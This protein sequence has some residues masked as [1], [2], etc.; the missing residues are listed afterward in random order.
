[1]VCGSADAL[2]AGCSDVTVANISATVLLAIWDNLLCVTRRPGYLILTGFETA[3]SRVI[4]ELVP[5]P[6]IFEEEDWVC[7]LT[8]LTE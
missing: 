4:E 8:R 6:T 3:E 5:D 1:L 2:L 7:L